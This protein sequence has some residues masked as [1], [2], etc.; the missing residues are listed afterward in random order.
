V[1]RSQPSTPLRTASAVRLAADGKVPKLVVD[2]RQ[3]NDSAVIVRTLA[4]LL[5]GEPLDAGIVELEKLNN[6]AG[7]IGALEKETASSY[8][9][10]AAAVVRRRLSRLAPGLVLLTSRPR[11]AARRAVGVGR[12]VHGPRR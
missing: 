4:P 3:I 11:V 7:L 1:R 10:I 2:G 6:V 8:W 9:G 12:D 5:S